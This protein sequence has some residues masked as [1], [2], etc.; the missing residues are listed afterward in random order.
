M[1]KSIEHNLKDDP[2]KDHISYF[3]SLSYPYVG[4]TVSV[5]VGDL[6]EACRSRHLSFFLTMVH[7]VAKAAYRVPE[8]RRR[9]KGEKIIE[10]SEC[11]T[12]HTVYKSDGT[13]AYCTL[14]HEGTLKDYFAVATDLHNA[15]K[16]SGCIHEDDDVEAEL[17][18]TTLPW[19]DYTALIQPVNGGD[20]SNPRI[21]WGRCVEGK[22]PMTVLCHHA[23]VDGSHIAEFFS[24]LGMTYQMM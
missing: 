21:S 19:L 6:M 18:I 7:A 11:P 4:V 10:F 5:E 3:R 16:E 15:C 23:L 22:M 9:L 20:D 13:F 14:K 1:I 8:F 24:Q 17:F 12:S 2:R